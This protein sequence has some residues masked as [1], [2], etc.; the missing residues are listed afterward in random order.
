MIAYKQPI[1][2]AEIQN[3]RGVQGSGVLKTLLRHKLI[4]PAGHR[5]I[6]GKPVL[7]KTTRQFLL[8]FGLKDLSELPSLEEFGQNDRFKFDPT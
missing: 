5:D 6:V 7:Y 2:A 3:I 8:H 4:A 1:T